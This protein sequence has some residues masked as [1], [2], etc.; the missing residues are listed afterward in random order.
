MKI[1]LSPR[2]IV[3]LTG[4]TVVSSSL[5]VLPQGI[6]DMALQNSWFVPFFIMVYMAFII[7]LGLIGTKNVHTFD[8]LFSE[9][10]SSKKQ[11]I[12][13]L[14]FIIFIFHVLFRDL[15]ILSAFV[16]STLL[17]L[18]PLFIITLIILICSL[19][20]ASLGIEVIVRFTELHFIIFIGVILFVP[21][22]LVEQIRLENFEPLISVDVIPSM[23]QSAYIGMAWFGEVIIVFLL[24]SMIKP[25]KK[26]RR[27]IILGGATGLF[28]FS[29]LI[30]SQLGVIGS[31]IVRYSTYPTY[32]LVQ[33]IRITEFLDRLDLALVTLY[34]PTIFSKFALFIYAL[35][36][37]WSLLWKNSIK[38]TMVPLAL[39]AG[40]LSIVIF[41]NKGDKYEFQI[42]TWATLSI[43]L[44]ILLAIMTLMMIKDSK[45]SQK[46]ANDNN[47]GINI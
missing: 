14:L 40:I 38:I 21:I 9:E 33:Q 30:F 16:E 1:Q 41:G 3:F 22:S 4:N 39:I 24:L 6:V 42:Y 20:I 43:T 13:A 45:K 32:T 18:T 11:K 26:L 7:L 8:N 36:R 27:A 10:N 34:L 46:N 15:R 37:A 31:E 29:I 28:C 12:A 35:H 5:V 47:T 19:Y 44:Q 23:F 2:Q 17:P 25:I